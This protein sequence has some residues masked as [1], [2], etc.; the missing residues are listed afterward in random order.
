MGRMACADMLGTFCGRCDCNCAWILQD[1]SVLDDYSDAGGKVR[2]V[3]CLESD[4][5]VVLIG[6]ETPYFFDSTEGQTVTLRPLFSFLGSRE[7]LQEGKRS[8]IKSSLRMDLLFLDTT[9]RVPVCTGAG[10]SVCTRE[11]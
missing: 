8:T 1:A 11:I 7:A 6:E 10:T 3:L 9:D 5:W 2:E 4:L